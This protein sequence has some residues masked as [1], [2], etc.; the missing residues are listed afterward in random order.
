MSTTTV[1]PIT[2]N[3]HRPKTWSDVALSINQGHGFNE[4]PHGVHAYDVQTPV[5]GHD[6]EGL[7]LRLHEK[8]D[9]FS[10]H[11]LNRVYAEQQRVRDEYAANNVRPARKR[12]DVSYVVMLD[13]QAL[14]WVARNRTIHMNHVLIAKSA[15]VAVRA[16]EVTEKAL[17][18]L[19]TA[20]GNWHFSLDPQ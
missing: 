5:C 9:S 12:G 11:V 13:G 14:G 17:R 15:T 6:G 19:A 8:R 4:S 18:E 3:P 2:R 1:E 10:K 16:Y 20:T 7:A